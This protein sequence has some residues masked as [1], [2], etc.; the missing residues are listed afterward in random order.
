MRVI[1]YGE[2]V[3]KQVVCRD[4]KSLIAYLPKDI[5]INVN[6]GW[7]FITCPVCLKNIIIDNNK[8]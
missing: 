7:E 1:K 8:N 2:N 6:Y 4:C 3:E 5:D